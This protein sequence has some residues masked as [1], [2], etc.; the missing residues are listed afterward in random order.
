MVAIHILILI[1]KK[2]EIFVLNKRKLV[3]KNKIA[4]LT[5]SY[6]QWIGLYFVW[7]GNNFK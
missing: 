7:Y 4:L 5:F 1:D 6:V 2:H 3:L